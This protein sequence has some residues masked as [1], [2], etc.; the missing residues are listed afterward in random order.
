ML[1][2]KSVKSLYVIDYMLQTRYMTSVV[3]TIYLHSYIDEI[4][5]IVTSCRTDSGRFHIAALLVMRIKI[6][7][8]G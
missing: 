2:S 3:P 7:K 8:Y 4:Y 1:N 6:K 5:N